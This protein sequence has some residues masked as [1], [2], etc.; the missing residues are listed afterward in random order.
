MTPWRSE[1]IH[2]PDKNMSSTGFN[3]MVAMLLRK[4]ASTGRWER[5]ILAMGANI[6]GEAK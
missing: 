5:N 3:S 2:P 4:S 6:F 1:Q